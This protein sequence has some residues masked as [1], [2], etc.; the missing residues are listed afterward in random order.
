MLS[1]RGGI[2]HF[3]G[4]LRFQR[5]KVAIALGVGSVALVAGVR[6]PRRT[7]RVNV[8]GFAAGRQRNRWR[9]RDHFAGR[10]PGVR[11]A[12]HQDVVRQI[13]ANNNGSI[14]RRSPTAS[15]RRVPRSRCAALAPIT[16]SCSSPAAASPTSAS[17]RRPRVVSRPVADPVRRRRA[18]RNP[19]GRAS[20]IYG[21]DAV[22]GVVNV[23]LRQQFTASP[24][25]PPRA[26]T[27]TTATARGGRPR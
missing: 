18:H 9:H 3:W 2:N 19:E 4:F 20:A 8:T 17:R 27:G 10:H 23:I 12:D 22:A 14:A 24:L 26:P 13:T 25:P 7:S 16:P 1:A 11:S 5:R 15:R 6:R 21:S